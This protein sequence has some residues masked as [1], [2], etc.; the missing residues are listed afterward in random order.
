ME[1]KEDYLIEVSSD[2][3]EYW[4]YNI[5][6]EC[7]CFDADDTRCG[8]TSTEDVISPVG[9]GMRTKPDNYKSPRVVS[10][11]AESCDHLLIRL[12]IVPHLLPEDNIIS[13]SEPFDVDITVTRGGRR[14]LD[15]TLK[16]NRW[17]GISLPIFVKG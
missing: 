17:A 3:E 2:F 12:Y 16:I 14:L 9:A 1:I 6:I 5:Y 10:L 4:R 11:E 8:F 7:G 15:R 13:H